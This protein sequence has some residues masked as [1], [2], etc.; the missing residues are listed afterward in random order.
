MENKDLQLHQKPMMQMISEGTSR[1][2]IARKY[3]SITPTTILNSNF[4]SLARLRKERSAE[5]VERAIAILLID[6]SRAFGEPIDKETALE[7]AVEIHTRYY[8]LT[9]E[10]CYL[11]LSRMKSKPLYGK[12]SSNKFL[13]EFEAYGAERIQLADQMSYNNHLATSDAGTNRTGDTDS[14]K[15]IMRKIRS[16]R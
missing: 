14:V 15:G 11:V 10:D 1:V 7:T 5:E 6:A 3:T 4:P 2:E 13:T 12:L 16:K 9:L 8:Y